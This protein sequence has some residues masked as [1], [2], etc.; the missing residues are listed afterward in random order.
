LDEILNYLTNAK[1]MEL[2]G[3]SRV[4]FGAG[5]LFLLALFFRWK[6]ILALLFAFGGT[7]TVMRYAEL[8]EGNTS[9]DQ[10]LVIFGVGTVIV[11]AVLIYY[12][13]IRSE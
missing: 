9:I 11:A 3:D 5:V 4:L 2:A 12:L 1:I 10:N 13:F 7:I 8:S 6:L